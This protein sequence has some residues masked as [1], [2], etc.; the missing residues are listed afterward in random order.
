M[1]LYCAKCQRLFEDKE[2][3]PH[4]LFSRLREPL[5][6]DP[7]LLDT[8]DF[9]R[10]EMLKPLLQDAGIPFSVNGGVGAAFGMGVGMRLDPIR[11]YVPYGALEEAGRLLNLLINEAEPTE[12]S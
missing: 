6:N 3:C 12:E 7:V 1:M 4:C 5:E 11:L 10:A 9:M 2:K 8:L